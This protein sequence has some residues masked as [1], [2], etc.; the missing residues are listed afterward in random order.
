MPILKI[1]RHKILIK[2]GSAHLFQKKEEGNTFVGNLFNDIN[3]IK[4]R[5][6]GCFFKVRRKKTQTFYSQADRKR[7]TLPSY[8]QLFMNF[9][10]ILDYDYMCSET[11]EKKSFLPNF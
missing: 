11:K 7:L 5:Y 8:G 9:C 3:R 1:P 6:L 4:Y 2:K 10:L